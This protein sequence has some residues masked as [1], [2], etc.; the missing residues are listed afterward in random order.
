MWASMS[1]YDETFSEHPVLSQVDIEKVEDGRFV[2]RSQ[3]Y[4]FF[5]QKKKALIKHVYQHRL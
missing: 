4:S 5:G 2:A 3:T 1:G